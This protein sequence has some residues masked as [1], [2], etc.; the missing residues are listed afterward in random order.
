MY[1]HAANRDTKEAAINETSN[2]NNTQRENTVDAQQSHERPNSTEERSGT[3]NNSTQEEQGR[4]SS[5]SQRNGQ[6]PQVQ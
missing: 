6:R 1:S 3:R 2:N 5:Q 4:P